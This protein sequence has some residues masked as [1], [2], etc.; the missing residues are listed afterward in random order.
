MLRHRIQSLFVV[1]VVLSSGVALGQEMKGPI[2]PFK[3]SSVRY[4]LDLFAP[5]DLSTYG[6]WPRPNEGFFFQY[7]RLYWS[8]QQPSRTEIGVPGGQAQGLINGVIQFDPTNQPVGQILSDYSNSLDTGFLRADQTWGNRFELGWMEDN[9][10]WFVSIFN[11]QDQDQTN[12]FGESAAVLLDQ[13]QIPNGNPLGGLF[14]V[15]NDPQNRLLGF[16]DTNRDGFDDDLNINGPISV[17]NRVPSVFGRPNQFAGEDGPFNLDTDNDGVPDAY[18]G[19]PDFGD[20]VWLVPS[21]NQI[22]VRNST[23]MAGVELSR[24]W[25]YDVAHRGGVWEAFFGVRWLLYRDRFNVVA[26]NDDPNVLDGSEPVAL[27]GT[28]YWNSSIDN[29][30]FGPQIGFRYK[31]SAG[32]FSVGVEGRFL[33]AA[34]FQSIHLDG[35][36][37]SGL[38]QIPDQP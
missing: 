7:D 27:P 37:A 34:N 33:A 23:S 10:G 16:V 38:L 28:S 11:L 4:D 9:K 14:I 35:E 17:T 20:M 25:R 6:N 12:V 1:A 19:F 21:F 3:P 5:P 24:S 2:G 13:D 15:F 30:M 29:N 8:I 18:A 26:I 32:R 31:Q 22:T 36:L